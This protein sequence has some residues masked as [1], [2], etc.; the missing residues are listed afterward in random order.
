MPAHCMTNENCVEAIV[1][2]GLS[3]ER[4]GTGERRTAACSVPLAVSA[5]VLLLLA[6]CG[7]N[8]RT[9][10]PFDELAEPG[11]EVRSQPVWEPSEEGFLR[12]VRHACGGLSVGDSTVAALLERDPGFLSLTTDLYHGELSND[13]Y[14]RR[15]LEAHPAA[16]ANIEATGCVV[17]QLQTCFGGRC[18]VPAGTRPLPARDTDAAIEAFGN[19]GPPLEEPPKAAP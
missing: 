1:V 2:P 14:A 16:D 4:R 5:G 9:Q 8:P 7:G 11:P 19:E 13:G 17:N 12:L 3:A 6:G 15:V 18:D 10:A